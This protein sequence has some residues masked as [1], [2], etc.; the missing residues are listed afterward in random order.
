MKRTCLSAS[1]ALCVAVASSPLH[2]RAQDPAPE[3][4]AQATETTSTSGGVM[5]VSSHSETPD[6]A[7]VAADALVVRPVGLAA[8]AIGAAIFVVALPFAAI[9]GD[10]KKTGK[11]LVGAPANFTFKRKLGDFEG[12]L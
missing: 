11:T 4:K 1:V 6:P 5:A 7:E 8:T 2:V 9:S 10:V 12:K 3:T